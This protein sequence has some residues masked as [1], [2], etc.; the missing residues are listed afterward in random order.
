MIWKGEEKHEKESHK[1]TPRS[2]FL[3]DCKGELQ[4]IDNKINNIQNEINNT[5]GTGSSRIKVTDDKP[6][7]IKL[8]KESKV[9]I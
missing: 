1:I 3:I 7:K 9:C 4:E 5:L 2:N 8:K 6:V